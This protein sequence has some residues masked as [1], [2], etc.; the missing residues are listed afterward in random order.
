MYG[1]I[2]LIKKRKYD[3]ILV[4][5]RN[6]SVSRYKTGSMLCEYIFEQWK[7]NSFSALS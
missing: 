4:M 2:T 6:Y 7:I 5:Y 1:M 3:I